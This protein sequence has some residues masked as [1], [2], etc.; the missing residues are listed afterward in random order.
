[1]FYVVRL[2]SSPVTSPF[3]ASRQCG[4]VGS[5]WVLGPDHFGE[6]WGLSCTSHSPALHVCSQGKSA[7][8]TPSHFHILIVKS[9]K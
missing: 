8:E 3:S 2:Y 4:A 9:C 1:M 7:K 5:T 6:V